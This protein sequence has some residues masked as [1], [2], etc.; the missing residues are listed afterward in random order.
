MSLQK[1]NTRNIV[2]IL[3][4]LAA[5]AFRFVSYEYK[6]LS[7]FTPVGA[8]ALFGGAYFTD[9]WKAYTV[10]L[11]ALF[12]SDIGINYLYT[13][14]LVFWYSGS[15]LVY[16]TF[17]IM[18][19]IGSLIKKANVLNVALASLVSVVIHWLI[20]DMPWLYGTLYP[21]TFAGYGQSLVAAIPFEK[22]MILGDALFCALLFGGFE[23]AQS[24]Y[25]I[26]RSNQQLAV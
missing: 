19:F 20:I 2:L 16:L 3:M 5:I 25:I 26:L 6:F 23:F 22:N 1:I 14:K 11:V 12:L 13:S 10:V 9:K 17:A 7:N 8:I 21:H 24:K 4:I 18:V 15:A